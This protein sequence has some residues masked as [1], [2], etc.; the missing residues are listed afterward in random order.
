MQG[1]TTVLYPLSV[2]KTQ[3]MAI[4]DAPRGLR[5]RREWLQ[6]ASLAAPATAVM[7]HPNVPVLDARN[8]AEP[9]MAMACQ[10]KSGGRGGRQRRQMCRQ[11]RRRR[12]RVVFMAQGCRQEPSCEAKSTLLALQ[13]AQATAAAIVR[14]DGVR[15]LYRGFG[16]T[17]FGL[18]PAR[19]VSIWDSWLCKWCCSEV[20]T[21]QCK[22]PRRWRHLSRRGW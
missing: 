9:C 6:E 1:V 16:T 11:R 7:L 3:Q 5:V 18:V 14:A 8:R 12:L 20:E 4:A 2:V 21:E 10:R 15:G 22:V 13:G 17:I 19:G